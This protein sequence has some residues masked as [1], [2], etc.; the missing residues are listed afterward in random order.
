MMRIK[1]RHAQGRGL[2]RQQGETLV[3]VIA[4]RFM[5]A[6]AASRVV[7]RMKARL[8]LGPDDVGIA[9]LG[10]ADQ[11]QGAQVLLA[12]RFREARLDEIRSIIERHGGEIVADLDE[13][14]TRPRIAPTPASPQGRS[15]WSGSPHFA[16]G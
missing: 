4:A 6:E 3:R 8:D 11:P 16:K 14:R 5:E 15:V 12:G 7:S 2:P 13:G 9:P 1:R 10:G